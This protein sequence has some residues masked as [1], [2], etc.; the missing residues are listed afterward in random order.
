MTDSIPNSTFSL[1]SERKSDEE[2]TET[3]TNSVNTT[4]T[5]TSVKVEENAP[6]AQYMRLSRIS[7][8]PCRKRKLRC[9]RTMPC[10]TCVKRGI[11]DK[12]YQETHAEDGKGS[13]VYSHRHQVRPRSVMLHLHQITV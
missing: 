6:P 8:D 13:S 2:S 3:A 7:C 10:T 4:I 1:P 9:S 11:A 5:E 12:C